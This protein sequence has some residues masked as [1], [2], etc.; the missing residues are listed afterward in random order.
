MTTRIRLSLKTGILGG[1]IWGILFTAYY[2]LLPNFE[3]AWKSA[4]LCFFFIFVV[5]LGLPVIVREFKKTSEERKKEREEE[6]K[7]NKI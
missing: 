2:S 7:R 3:F 4:S 6:R 5:F 1:I